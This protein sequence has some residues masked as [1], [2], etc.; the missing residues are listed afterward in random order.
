EKTRS[1]I[2]NANAQRRLDRLTARIFRERGNYADFHNARR[3]GQLDD[4]RQ[5][6]ITAPRTTGVIG[7]F[8]QAYAANDQDAMR[9]LIVEGLRKTGMSAQQVQNIDPRILDTATAGL[10]TSL[11]GLQ[12]KFKEKGFDMGKALSQGLK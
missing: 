11:T 9:A 2:G 8:T 3:S 6:L 12:A 10:M 1:Q 4:F 5:N 7:R